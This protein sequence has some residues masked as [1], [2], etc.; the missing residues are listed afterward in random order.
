MESV[1]AQ[2]VAFA[3]RVDAKEKDAEIAENV[4]DARLRRLQRLLRV[5]KDSGQRV[6]E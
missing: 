5:Q 6:P 3:L 4:K 1:E 2:V